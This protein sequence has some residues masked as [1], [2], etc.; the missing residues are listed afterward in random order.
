MTADPAATHRLG[1]YGSRNLSEFD[2]DTSFADD[3][4]TWVPA[5]GWGEPYMY[6][7]Y[8]SFGGWTWVAAPWVWGFGPW[9]Y[10]GAYGAFGFDWY[11]A[12]WWRSIRAA[13]STWFR[14]PA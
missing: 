2:L 11:A 10:F 1:I 13:S 8:P 3:T 6:V 14:A 7:Y 12:G 4:Y 9:P 5:D